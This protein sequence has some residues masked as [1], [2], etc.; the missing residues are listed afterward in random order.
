M[1]NL[2]FS[3][4]Y[5]GKIFSGNFPI[6]IIGSPRT[7]AEIHFNQ[8]MI[9]VIQLSKTEANLTEKPLYKKVIKD[10]FASVFDRKITNVKIHNVP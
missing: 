1:I 3:Y 5:C 6:K 2:E 7:H 10:V 8:K 9:L 4:E